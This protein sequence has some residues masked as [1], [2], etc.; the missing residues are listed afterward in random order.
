MPDTR[1]V[2]R[3]WDVDRFAVAAAFV[4]VFRAAAVAAN[5][6]AAPVDGGVIIIVGGAVVVDVVEVDIVVNAALEEEDILASLESA[7]STL[8]MGE[9]GVVGVILPLS[10]I[11]AFSIPAIDDAAAPTAELRGVGPRGAVGIPIIGVDIIRG[12]PGPIIIGDGCCCCCS[13]WGPP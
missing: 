2:R 10:I 1:A 8:P 6:P 13:I 12:P 5:V 3:R 7:E 9:V 4:V 11:E